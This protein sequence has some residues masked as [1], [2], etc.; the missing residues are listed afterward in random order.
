MDNDIERIE[1]INKNIE[2]ARYEAVHLLLLQSGKAFTAS[3]DI[4]TSR[5]AIVLTSEGKVPGSAVAT[6]LKVIAVDGATFD[7]CVWTPVFR[8]Y[9]VECFLRFC[10]RFAVSVTDKKVVMRD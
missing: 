4:S 10:Q 3:M 5:L 7:I 6:Y 1:V 2:D 8:F 9:S